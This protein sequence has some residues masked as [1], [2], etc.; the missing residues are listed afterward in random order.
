M[1]ARPRTLSTTPRRLRHLLLVSLGQELLGERIRLAR[2]S[3]G[4]SQQELA[5]KAGLA[6]GQSISNYE[7]NVAEVPAKRLRLIATATA[8]PM[9]YFLGEADPEEEPLRL[10]IREETAEI[11][12]LVERIAAHLGLDETRS[13][14][15]GP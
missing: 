12:A 15:D 1:K 5:E 11:R 6:Q 13:A 3:A 2:E 10:A 8:K 4:L 14:E 9:S 7:R